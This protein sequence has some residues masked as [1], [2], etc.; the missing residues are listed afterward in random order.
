MTDGYEN[1]CRCGILSTCDCKG[2]WRQCKHGQV[3]KQNRYCA[4]YM[5]ECNHCRSYKA[6]KE[7]REAK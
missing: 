7:A 2:D 4:F 6:Q 3:D 5:K 1:Q